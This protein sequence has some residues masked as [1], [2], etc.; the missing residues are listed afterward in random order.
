MGD[1]DFDQVPHILFN[2]ISNLRRRGCPGTLIPL[3][4][5]TRAVLCG[6]DSNEVIAVAIR[7]G[8]GKCLVFAHCDYPYI[9]LNGEVDDQNFVKNCR[10]WLIQDENAQFVSINDASSMNDV[11]Y[12]GKILVWDGHCIKDETFMNDLCV[13]LQQG[14]ALICGS[15]A[16]GWLQVNKGKFLSDFPFTRFCDYIGVKVTDNYSN[17]PDPIPFRSELIEF[18]NIYH[19]VQELANDPNNIK[20]LTIIGSALKELGDTLPGVVAETLQNIVLNAGNE[21]VP[22]RSCPVLD[23]SCRE[24]STGLCGILCGLPGIKACGI[25]CFPGDFDQPPRIETDVI[26]HI[27]SNVNEWYCTGFTFLGYYVAA[28]IPIKIDIV[29]QVGA[30]G[31]SARIGCHSDNLESCDELRRWSCISICKP[32][33]GTS[34]RMSS[35]FGGLLFLQSPD[36]ESNL[37]IVRLHHVVLTPTYDL[38]DPYREITWQDRREYEGLWADIAGQHI[39]FNL[40]SK[41][42]HNLDSAQLDEVLQFW[43]T[44]VLAHHELRGTTPKHRERIVCDEQPSVGYMHSGYPIMT[45]LDVCDPK[46]NEFI[47]NGPHLKKN[48]CW[49][50]F[51]ELGHNMQRDWWTFA[52][53]VEVTVNIFT[54]HAMD[55]VCHIQPWIHSW[56]RDQISDIKKYIENGSKFHAWKNSPGVGLFVY[57]QL[58]REYGWDNYKAV[59]RQYEQ[60]RPVLHND[61]EKMDRWIETFSRQVGYNLIP[62]FKFW[63]FPVSQSTIDALLT[64]EI[65]DISDEFIEM[66]PERYQI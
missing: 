8:D 37:I 10:Q 19:V 49:G 53:S 27:D 35:P 2:G 14:G 22:A 5:N 31:W 1:A 16:W 9:F 11:Q 15:V 46:S 7:F 21:L 25:H 58:V 60:T 32:L 4:H 59:F 66:A 30:T 38:T 51:H 50:L 54:L 52:G 33:T 47:L 13:Y 34:V 63:G 28:G 42:V 64:L 20:N 57:A 45:H 43:D 3:T 40:P 62:L 36:G 41:S 44:V 23:K 48:G 18:K 17:C 39:V 55:T 56:L 24:Q 65:A 26:C 61:Q 6:N 12:Y 29:E